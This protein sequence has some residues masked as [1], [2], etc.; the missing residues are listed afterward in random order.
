MRTG[1]FDMAEAGDSCITLSRYDDMPQTVVATVRHDVWSDGMQPLGHR[2]NM[3]PSS[4]M[5]ALLIALMALIAFGAPQLRRLLSSLDTDLLG[6]RRRANAFESHTASESH[7]LLLLLLA[8]CVCQ[9][10]LIG[11]AIDPMS[12]SNGLLMG[13]LLLLTVGYY[14]F[15]YV[16]YGV[17]GYTFTDKINAMQWRKGFNLS[18]GVLGL[19][20]LLPAVTALYYHKATIVLVGVG[21]VL[22]LIARVAFICKGF[23]I[24]YNELSSLVYFILYLCALEIIPAAAVLKLAGRLSTM[25]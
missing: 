23:R 9:A 13:R 25:A 10:I 6:V 3:L 5:V 18:Q 14:M 22:Y 21:V 16:A 8:G 17:I 20:L 1:S 2:G 11:V 12:V 19:T 15:Q 24:F 7:M 4:G